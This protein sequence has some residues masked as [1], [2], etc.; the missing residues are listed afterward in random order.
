MLTYP[1]VLNKNTTAEWSKW[2]PKPIQLS[3]ASLRTTC[4]GEEE[5]DQG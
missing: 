4:L 5:E 3:Q 1:T 2:S